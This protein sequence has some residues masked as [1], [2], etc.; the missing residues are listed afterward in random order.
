MISCKEAIHPLGT[1]LSAINEG[2]SSSSLS[3]EAEGKVV[4]NDLTRLARTDR[5]AASV[6]RPE[7]YVNIF[8]L[9]D[10]D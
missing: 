1:G 3:S 8:L 9:M 7:D 10:E 4:A 2:R 5:I 6:Y